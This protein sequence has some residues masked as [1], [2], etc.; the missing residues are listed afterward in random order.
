MIGPSFLRQRKHT[1]KGDTLVKDL[2]AFLVKFY[3]YFQNARGCLL[4]QLTY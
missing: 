2:A 1:L 4:R 3:T